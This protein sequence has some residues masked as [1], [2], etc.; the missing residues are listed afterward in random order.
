M[1]NNPEFE[2]LRTAILAL[3]PVVPGTLRKVYVRCG[4]KNCRCQIGRKSYW[5]G[6]YFFLGSQGR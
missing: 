4:K 6:P 5:H 2:K 3:G 1:L